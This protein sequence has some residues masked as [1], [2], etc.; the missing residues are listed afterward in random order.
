MSPF[1]RS[2]SNGASRIERVPQPHL[3]LNPV[4]A[5]D[6]AF[7]VVARG[8]LAL[9]SNTCAEYKNISDS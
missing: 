2:E 1:P 9:R 3:R 6:T 8:C 5:L 7:R 4:M